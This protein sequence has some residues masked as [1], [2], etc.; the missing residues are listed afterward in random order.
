MSDDAMIWPS[1]R[2][3]SE[4]NQSRLRGEKKKKKKHKKLH[5]PLYVRT[6]FSGENAPSHF[7]D[8]I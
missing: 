5:T 1:I 6:A 3:I 7:L 8:I 4:L 2:S